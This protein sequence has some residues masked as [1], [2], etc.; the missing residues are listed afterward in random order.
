MNGNILLLRGNGTRKG[1][2][3]QIYTGVRH[4]F[5]TIF[6]T[7]EK[8]QRKVLHEKQGVVFG[9]LAVALVFELVLAGCDTEPDP[10]GFI[11]PRAFGP[12]AGRTD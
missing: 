8:P 9:L 11:R 2:R 4:L 10:V 5:R 3:H 7:A 1:D 6:Q 12:R